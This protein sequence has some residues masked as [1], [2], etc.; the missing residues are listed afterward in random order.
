MLLTLCAAGLR[1]VDGRC[2]NPLSIVARGVWIDVE[3]DATGGRLRVVGGQGQVSL[4]CGQVNKRSNSAV[5]AVV[6]PMEELAKR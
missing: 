3:A 1:A 5:P 6:K 2:G 4:Q